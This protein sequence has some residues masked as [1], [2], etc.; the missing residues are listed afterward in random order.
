MISNFC[1]I[2]I[3][4]NYS[5]RTFDTNKESKLIIAM[6]QGVKIINP[7]WIWQF[8]FFNENFSFIPQWL[9]VMAKLQSYWLLRVLLVAASV[10]FVNISDCVINDEPR[11]RLIN[12]F[13]FAFFRNCHVL[14]SRD[15]ITHMYNLGS[16][17]SFNNEDWRVLTL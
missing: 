11:K 15:Y 2:I 14:Y 13:S 3:I 16:S 1:L 5:L 10:L 7:A 6:L 17:N 4:F 12:D 9:T 8:F